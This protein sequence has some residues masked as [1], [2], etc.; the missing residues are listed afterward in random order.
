MLFLVASLP[1]FLF[2]K[3]GSP[4]KSVPRPNIEIWGERGEL[5]AYWTFFLPWPFQKVMLCWAFPPLSP[6]RKVLLLKPVL[7][8]FSGLLFD[9]I[10]WP[11]TV[12]TN[13]SHTF[14]AT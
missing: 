7:G 4:E 3:Q 10:T 12:R 5:G 14:V 13:V 9:R 8:T 1:T 11:S 2:A 6:F